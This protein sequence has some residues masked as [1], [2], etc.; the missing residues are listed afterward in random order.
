MRGD[1]LPRSDDPDRGNRLAAAAQHLFADQMMQWWGPERTIARWPVLHLAPDVDEGDGLCFFACLKQ[2]GIPRD[3][4][5]LRLHD[6]F[7]RQFRRRMQFMGMKPNIQ[8][9]FA[10]VF[11]VNV[12]WLDYHFDTPI[13]L[14]RGSMPSDALP[15]LD[16]THRVGYDSV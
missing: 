5:V 16:Y 14:T 10:K 11:G 2:V 12:C 6:D 9:H 15:S 13:D 3:S 8:R 4:D 1:E 7:A